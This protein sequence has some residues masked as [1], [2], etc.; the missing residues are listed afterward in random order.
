MVTPDPATRAFIEVDREVALP[1]LHSG[2]RRASLRTVWNPIIPEAT[3]FI[4]ARKPAGSTAVYLDVSGSMNQE[5]TRIA[6]L[7]HRHQHWIRH[8]F[9]SFSNK[10][11]SAQFMN[12]Q[13]VTRSTGGTNLDCVFNHIAKIRPAKT[14]I[15]TDGYVEEPK[16]TWVGLAKQF[17]VEF[18]LSAGGS[19][20]RLSNLDCPV[21]K[22]PELPSATLSPCVRQDNLSKNESYQRI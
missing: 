17:G 11:E 5:L 1:V 4:V 22:L 14:L 3:W 6:S 8:P 13:L 10:V 18:L 12:G 20:M 16:R 7:L 9:W 15:V 21:T 2:D 19:Q